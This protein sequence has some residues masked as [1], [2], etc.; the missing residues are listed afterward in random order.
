MWVYLSEDEC[1]KLNSLRP[2]PFSPTNK[3][4]VNG[5]SSSSY[6]FDLAG[7]IGNW[8]I[9]VNRTIA[10]RGLALKAGRDPSMSLME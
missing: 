2:Q 8:E 6:S 7:K 4:P 5:K 10:K 3:N 1:K 9:E